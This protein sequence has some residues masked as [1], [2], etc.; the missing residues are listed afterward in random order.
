MWGRADPCD[1]YCASNVAIATSYFVIG[2]V[3]SLISTPLNIYMVEVL[4]AEPQMQN[5]ISILQTLPWSLKLVF[6]FLSDAYPIF[7]MHRK[8]Y[9]FLGCMLYSISFAM[10]SFS[11]VHSAPMLAA[12]VFFGTLGLIMLDV[13]T[14]TMCVER[15]KFEEEDSRGQMQAT[16]YSIRFAGGVIGALLGTAVTSKDSPV[17]GW[18]YLDFP[19]VSFVNALIPFLFVSPFLFTLKEQYYARTEGL[20]TTMP[21]DGEIEVG[22]GRGQYGAVGVEL[23]TMTPQSRSSLAQQS[24]R[25]APVYSSATHSDVK[26]SILLPGKAIDAEE[27][28]ERRAALQRPVPS[29]NHQV[30]EI[31]QTVQLKAVVRPM[32]F[33]WLYN[34][35]QVPNVAWQSYLQLTLHFEPWIIGLTATVGSVMTFFGVLA[36]KHFFFRAS[37]RKIYLYTSFLTAFFSLLQ[38]ALIFQLNT[39]FHI[40]NYMFSLGDDVISQYVSGI[41]FLPMCLM[42]AKLCPVGAEGT[43][44]AL[45]TTFGNIALV[46]GSS[47]GNT[48]SSAFD[49]SNDTLRAGNIDGLWRLNLTTSLIALA[50]LF[51]LFLLPRDAAE[52]DEMSKSPARS[53]FG[54]TVFLSVL[55]L[56]LSW[57]IGNA[58]R[59]V[60]NAGL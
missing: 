39:R 29:I 46:V 41:Q 50:P 34:F 44:Y 30:E 56:S 12:A 36:Y 2:L 55:F 47:M 59:D 57:T 54:G 19:Q 40:S 4:D 32:A 17:F 5:T 13:M 18:C 35:L 21:S 43:S 8:P 3:S 38:L 58:L 16:C 25:A 31:W 15:S 9:F 1:L 10:Y 49:V 51:F 37:W 26:Y 33:V 28:G 22:G 7:G 24:V 60:L 14:D 53:R 27:E 23:K 11:G 52:Q 6:G 20:L 45:L 48:L 42:Y